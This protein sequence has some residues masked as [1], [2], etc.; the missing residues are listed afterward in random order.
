M[1]SGGGSDGAVGLAAIQQAGGLAVVEDPLDAAFP[2]MP[3]TAASLCEPDFVV[4]T[5]EIPA[6]LA[7]VSVETI[8]A[9]KA[10]EGAP[11]AMEMNE[12]DRP[13]TFSCPECGGALRINRKSGFHEYGCH[14]G[15]RFGA[16]DLLEAQSEGVERSIY[17]AF[18]MLNEQ[19]EFARRMI[20]SA[21]DAP[22]DNGLVYWERLQVQAE[23]QAEMLRRFLEQRPVVASEAERGS[24]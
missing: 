15:H 23:E 3:R 12:F 13:V 1:L 16:R 5:A 24:F 10:R 22:L 9:V 2:D 14:V 11:V 20:A 21:R 8:E 6:L 4:R 18:R 7:R 17:V 19:A